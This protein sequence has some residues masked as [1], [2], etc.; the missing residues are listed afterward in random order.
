MEEHVNDQAVWDEPV[1]EI[2]V[3]D[4]F[5]QLLREWKTILKWMAGFLIFAL[6]I[7][8][9]LPDEYVVTT[10]M[11]P[12]SPPRNANVSTL[13]SMA[14]INLAS[15]TTDA[16]S[17]TVFQDIIQSNPFVT[18]LFPVEVS[19]KF[20]KDIAT[21]DYY[22]YMRDI[23]REPWWKAVMR[24]PAKFI[25][26]FTG[27]FKERKEPVVGYETLDLSRLTSEQS[28]VA[29]R[30]R[31]SFSLE[32]KDVMIVMKVTAQDPS[33]ATT[34]SQEVVK[35]LQEYVTSYRT[36]KSRKSLAYYQK[37]YE[38]YQQKYFTSQQ[39]Y[40]RYV[41][42]HQNVVLQSVRTEQERL[43]NEMNL[44]YQLYNSCAQQLQS[45]QAKVQ[46]ETPVLTVINPP[47]YPLKPAKPARFLIIVALLFLGALFG[48]FWVLL[49]RGWVK[50]LK[51]SPQDAE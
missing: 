25:R 33:V 19:Y 51:E 1:K 50:E 8:I 39:R 10:K 36:E 27:L 20:K 6:I 41:D 28:R 30:I 43:Q 17:P 32:V 45:A 42:S 26:W 14:G 29:S 5:R 16:F 38:E 24:A 21:S 3:M 35:R 44:N 11:V 4:L 46:E 40:A 37:L 9:S 18:D 7:V 23:F 34:I 49:G 15:S 22:S 2:R 47:A 31:E 12:E 13:A 48:A